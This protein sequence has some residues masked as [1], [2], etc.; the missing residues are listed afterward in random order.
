MHAALV[1][2][3]VGALLVA[4]TPIWSHEVGARLTSSP[5]WKVTRKALDDVRAVRRLRTG[6]GPWLLPQDRMSVLS[7]GFVRPAA[8]VPRKIYLVGVEESPADALAR[9]RLSRLGHSDR[10][11][12]PRSQVVPA[13]RRLD[14]AL[15]CVPSRL[16]TRTD[17]VDAI[18]VGRLRVA[19]GLSCGRPPG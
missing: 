16:R 10:P 13:L 6:P 11:L 8:L 19:G 15:V 4:G 17:Y 9:R 3:A 12:P 14:V 1:V 18:T 5:T 7:I 2:V